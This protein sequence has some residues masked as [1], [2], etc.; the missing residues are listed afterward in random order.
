MEFFNS[1]TVKAHQND[2]QI[3]GNDWKESLRRDF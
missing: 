1:L 3:K 2:R